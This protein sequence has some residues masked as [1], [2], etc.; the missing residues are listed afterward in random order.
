MVEK[1]QLSAEIGLS[2][3]AILKKDFLLQQQTISCWA[4]T[5]QAVYL[6]P[7]LVERFL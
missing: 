4:T 3:L 1:M 6:S 7:F 2:G 5:A